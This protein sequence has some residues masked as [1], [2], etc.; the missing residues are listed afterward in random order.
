MPRSFIWP[1]Y[2]ALTVIVLV[3]IWSMQVPGLGD[4]MNHLARMHVLTQ[5]DTSPALQRF[6]EVHWTP[7]PYL[8]M[9]A[10]VPVLARA[11]PLYVAGKIFVMA[12]VLM[13]VLG[14]ASLH[15][16]VQRRF[17]LVP[18]AGFLLSYNYLLATGFLNYLFF[19]GI[20][21]VAVCPVGGQRR[22]PEMV[23]RDRVRAIPAAAIFRPRVRLPRLL[24][25]SCR[26]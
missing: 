1:I 13:P 14:G 22:T 3:P 9:D 6:Y 26:I 4:T 23:A 18:A 8:A 25:F 19:H 20:C 17:S 2:A 7:I 24:P 11:M 21:R 16:A 10:I 12:C 15:Y 5:I